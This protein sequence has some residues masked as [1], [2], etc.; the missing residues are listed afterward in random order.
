MLVYSNINRNNYT[1]LH[2]VDAAKAWVILFHFKNKSVQS[3]LYEEFSAVA[4]RN[5][6]GKTRSNVV[7]TKVHSDLLLKS[8]ENNFRVTPSQ[9]CSHTGWPI[10]FQINTRTTRNEEGM[11]E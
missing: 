9:V 3:M 10:D 11:V 2:D 6:I 8:F 5:C 7:A 1:Q 4:L